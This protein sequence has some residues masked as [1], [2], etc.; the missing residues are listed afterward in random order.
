MANLR[1]SQDSCL[2]TTSVAKARFK[3]IGE[4]LTTDLVCPSCGSLLIAVPVDV[5]VEDIHI[6]PA[7]F[8]SLPSDEKKKILKK[9]A[10]RHFDKFDKQMVEFKRNEAISA[11]KDKFEGGIKR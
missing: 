7:R 11:I 4:V 3:L 10:K 1:C 2:Y 8:K 9:R 6:A 5:K